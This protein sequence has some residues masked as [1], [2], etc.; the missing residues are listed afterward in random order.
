M[1]EQGQTYRRQH[2]S[3]NTSE[4]MEKPT[5]EQVQPL[6]WTTAPEMDYSPQKNTCQSRYNPLKETTAHGETPIR[7]GRA[8]EKDCRYWE[9]HTTAAEKQT[10]RAKKLMNSSTTLTPRFCAACGLNEGA[11]YNTLPGDGTAGRGKE[12]C[13]EGG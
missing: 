4:G 2:R 5:Q 11:V 6:K 7:A 1:P 10:R 9:S 12:K 8:P 3:R 13:P